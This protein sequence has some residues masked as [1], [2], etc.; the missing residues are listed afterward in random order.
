[1]T[2]MAVWTLRFSPPERSWQTRRRSAVNSKASQTSSMRVVRTLP[3][4]P[5]E[6]P[7]ESEVLLHGERLVH[8]GGLRGEPDGALRPLRL[9]SHIDAADRDPAGIGNDQ[10]GDDRHQRGLA[11]AV[12]TEEPH[13]RPGVHRQRHA[14][15]RPA[16][17]ERLG[18]GVHL[19]HRSLGGAGW[20]MR[21]R[22]FDTISYVR[23]ADAFTPST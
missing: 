15:E 23:Y 18:D 21:L 10:A 4:Q 3:G 12:G 8:A 22:M 7:E 5:G 11:G 9:A 19:Q 2:A 16:S 20:H 13:D 1:M 14:V 6:T 17:A